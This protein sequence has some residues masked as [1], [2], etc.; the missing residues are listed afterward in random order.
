MNP[1]IVIDP[2]FREMISPLRAEER[3]QLEAN[4]LAE[5]CRDPLVIWMPSGI[6]LDGH[7]RYDICVAN[8]I[9]FKTTTLDLP[10][11]EAAAD[12]IDANQLGRRNL[13]PDQY[14]LFRGRRY[15]R[16]K[17]QGERT[18]KTSP[19]NEEKSSTTAERLAVQHGVSRPTIE[20]DGQ[21]ADAVATVKS[22]DP[23]IEAKVVRG[24]GPPK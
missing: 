6:L 22:V 5:G 9:E 10:D 18:D 7:N 15:K 11:R 8:G 23:E 13:T 3:E 24:N 16:L 14:S 4:I 21:F 17:R 19:Q 20:R 2:E 1:Q 12:W